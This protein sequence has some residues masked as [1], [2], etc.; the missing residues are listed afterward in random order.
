MAWTD[1]FDQ[2]FEARIRMLMAEWHVPGIALVLVPDEEGVAPIYLTHTDKSLTDKPITK[3]AC[4]VC[5]IR[6]MHADP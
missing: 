3:K 6:M 2:E 1:I 4:Q 5:L